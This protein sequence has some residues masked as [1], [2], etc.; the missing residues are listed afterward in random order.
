MYMKS[1]LLVRGK[2]KKYSL[3]PIKDD[4]HFFLICTNQ[5]D[6]LLQNR[7]SFFSIL[8]PLSYLFSPLN[9][10]NKIA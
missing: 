5:Y 6:S 7:N 2:R 1:I 10:Q 8:F 3:R 4:P 9:T